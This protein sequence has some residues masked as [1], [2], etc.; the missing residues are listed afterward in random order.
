MDITQF[1]LKAGNNRLLVSAEDRTELGTGSYGKQSTNPGGIWYTAQ[2]GIWQTVWLESVPEEYISELR[3]IPD[4]EEKRVLLEIPAGGGTDYAVFAD[5]KRICTGSF[6]PEGKAEISLPD[7]IL[8][9]PEN[10][11]VIFTCEDDFKTGMNIFA[12]CAVLYPSIAI[13]TFELI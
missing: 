3:I 5:G 4:T 9:T 7:C 13:L 6:S 2:S 11:Q 10:Q 1:A 12:L 8:W